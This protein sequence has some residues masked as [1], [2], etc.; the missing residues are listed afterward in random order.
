MICSRGEGWFIVRSLH[1][2]ESWG[3]HSTDPMQPGHGRRAARQ[4]LRGPHGSSSVKGPGL[5]Q[6]PVNR[7]GFA[8]GTLPAHA[9]S[10]EERFIVEWDRADGGVWYDILA[11][12]RPR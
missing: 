7:H 4:L 12:S 2:V 3:W 6:R 1:L 10:G 11:F 8:S 5:S 9:E